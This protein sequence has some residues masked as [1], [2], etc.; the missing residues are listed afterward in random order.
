MARIIPNT[1]QRGAA[2]NLLSVVDS[3]YAPARDRMGEAALQ[4]GFGD[5]SKLVGGMAQ[6]RREE[7]ITEVKIQA[8]Q[9]ALVG[10][11]PDVELTK[12]RMGG[13]FR[14][15]S[16]AYNQ[17][18][19][20]TMGKKAAIEFQNKAALDY[21]KSGMKR[22]TDPNRFREWMN[23]RVDG[24]LKDEQSQNPYFLAGAMP[25][26]QQATHNMSAAHT[27]NI[28]A[29]MER[30]HLAAIQTQADNIALKVGSGELSI[31][32]VIGQ[33]S[34]L[35]NQAY[36]TGLDGPKAR[37]A[38]ISSF[39]SV[40][41]ATDNKEMVDE[42]LA[43]QKSGTLRLTPSEWNGVVNQ[44]EAIQLD[45]DRRVAR[46]E[47]VA[48]AQAAAEV[49]GLEDG[50]TDFFNNPNN[51]AATFQ[52]FLQAP[53]DDSGMT[54]A[55][56]INQ[57]PNSPELL[58][59][60]KTAYDTVT[61]IYEI[62]ETQSQLNQVAINSAINDGTIT[63]ENEFLS[64]RQQAQKDGFR[65]N[66]AD[67][68]HAFSEL[69][70]LND[71]EA[72]FGTEAYKTYRKAT[73]NR[74]INAMTPDTDDLI[75]SFDGTYQ[76]TMADD[77]RI[78]FQQSVDGYLNAIP[79][80]KRLDPTSIKEAIFNAEKDVMDFFK[81]NDP[82]LF[83]KQFE[84]FTTAVNKKEISWTS[85]PYFAREAA[86]LV[87]EQQRLEAVE[88]QNMARNRADGA[89]DKRFDRSDLELQQGSS[90]LFGEGDGLTEPVM[91]N[92]PEVQAT[93]DAAN[94][95]Q[96]E[97]QR[98]AEEN[99]AVKVAEQEAKVAAQKADDAN[100]T[101]DSKIAVEALNILENITPE[102]AL[103]TLGKL[104]EQFNLTVPTNY[105]E[106]KFFTEDLQA[107]Q[108]EAGVNIDMDAFEKLYE[109]ALRQVNNEPIVENPISAQVT[110]PEMSVTPDG[111]EAP[112]V[113]TLSAKPVL[114][115]SEPLQLEV[116]EKLPEVAT[117]SRT[118]IPTLMPIADARKTPQYPTVLD[119]A[120]VNTALD[121]FN[122]MQ[123]SWRFSPSFEPYGET[124]ATPENSLYIESL[125]D[126]I[127][128]ILS[129]E[130]KEG[131][132][133]IRKVRWSGGG[134]KVIASLIRKYDV[135]SISSLYSFDS[136][137][138]LVKK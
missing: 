10:D 29:Q 110:V 96:V 55:E 115:P 41:D 4:K 17:V 138:K 125:D 59:K 46:Q 70:K 124:I 67:I 105:Q 77:L 15:N 90:I 38:L 107:L 2:R 86:E 16:R 93:V 72:S 131:D 133:V 129:G 45:I 50:V 9:D 85:N 108:Q 26:V 134:G 32:E 34:G 128:G 47:R 74:L 111:D 35:N 137:G 81:E 28:S 6:Q 56:Q 71:P 33:M 40:A 43:A 123:A 52:Q 57:S 87:K 117:L 76:G 73:E 7:E 79:P 106:L 130:L 61:S 20:E 97:G 31:K 100:L 127:H 53:V 54:M 60:A 103:E 8:Q 113:Q 63:S 132:V 65:F 119:D 83:N 49:A 51:A 99:R 136:D 126:Q 98:V 22:S 121:E 62:S 116:G 13:L 14:G 88:L 92:S 78:R 12:V 94:A 104:Q 37:K 25:Y 19:N 11:D 135:E 82:A 102:S 21:E 48:T 30:N 3:Y 66:N 42:L 120:D 89:V 39:L 84:D 118:Q 18:Y 112:T 44:G 23:E 64:W 95:A 91:P 75:P 36:A 69:E 1:P 5:V 101:S 114:Q 122:N 24:F 68:K 109:A 58:K 27:R 80:N